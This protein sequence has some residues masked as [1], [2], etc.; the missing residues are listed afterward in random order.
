MAGVS[1]AGQAEPFFRPVQGLGVD[2]GFCAGGVGVGEGRGLV[3]GFDE[4]LMGSGRPDCRCPVPLVRE[5]EG[6]GARVG[7][8]RFLGLR[9]GQRLMDWIS[10]TVT[11]VGLSMTPSGRP[12][13]P[14]LEPVQVTVQ[15]AV[16]FSW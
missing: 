12:K 5:K 16:T 10:W 3:S 4:A 14:P 15:R 8:G 2:G 9:L 1:G 7:A 11:G 6:A 13:G